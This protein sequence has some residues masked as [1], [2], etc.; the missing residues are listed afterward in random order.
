[1]NYFV[2]RK[3]R[4]IILQSKNKNIIIIVLLIII[5]AF[6]FYNLGLQNS[7][8]YQSTSLPYTGALMDITAST[9]DWSKGSHNYSVDLFFNKTK[10]V[11]YNGEATVSY[12]ATNGSWIKL[13]TQLLGTID[14]RGSGFEIMTQNCQF[15]PGT[16]Y[17]TPFYFDNN[18]D[19]VV[20]KVE[21]YA[22]SEP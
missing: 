21:A 10:G 11:L 2:F 9:G 6:V 18:Y 17:A 22:D 8:I 3:C 4:F 16:Q 12:L 19:L 7:P 13:P 1:M 14:A 20:I 15:V 5:T